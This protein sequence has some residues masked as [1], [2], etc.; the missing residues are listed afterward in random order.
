[1]STTKPTVP[2]DRRDRVTADLRGARARVQEHAAAQ[3]ITVAAFVRQAVLEATNQ[4]LAQ[5]EEGADAG[6]SSRRGIVKVTLRLPAVHALLLGRRAR[7]AELSQGTYVARLIDD[8][9][10]P[11]APPDRR[12]ALRQLVRAT[13]QLASIGTDLNAFMRLVRG[14]K[15]QQMESYR[16]GIISLS[17]DVRRHLSVL[18]GYLADINGSSPRDPGATR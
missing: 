12:E 15:S 7:A 10:P 5:T 8:A 3:G 16:A 14:G 1:M 2:A 13:D 6:P 9:P 18:S 11:A 17:S 4:P